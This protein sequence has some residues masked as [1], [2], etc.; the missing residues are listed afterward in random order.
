VNEPSTRSSLKEAPLVNVEH[1]DALFSPFSVKWEMDAKNGLEITDV[2]GGT[3]SL[4]YVVD[5]E[6]AT[7][8]AEGRAW[9]VIRQGADRTLFIN[10][11]HVASKVPGNL[12]RSRNDLINLSVP[13]L[14]NLCGILGLDKD[15]VKFDLM[16]SIANCLK[17]PVDEVAIP[18]EIYEPVAEVVVEPTP[19]PVAEVVP[20]VMTAAVPA[21][22]AMPA[23]PVVPA[24]TGLPVIRPPAPSTQVEALMITVPLGKAGPVY[25][26]YRYVDKRYSEWKGPIKGRTLENLTTTLLKMGTYKVDVDYGTTQGSD[27]RRWKFRS[28]TV[29]ARAAL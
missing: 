29:T 2:M 24:S 15:G 5:L 13:E 17:I 16:S 10:D 7:F 22:V 9:R 8:Q 25:K 28:F 21:E 19:E 20:E 23:E 4:D 26:K 6:R 14:R 3:L 27:G 18:A 11:A 1:W 12:F